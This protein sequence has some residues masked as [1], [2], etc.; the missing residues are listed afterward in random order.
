MTV[1]VDPEFNELYKKYTEQHPTSSLD[2]SDP[3]AMRYEGIMSTIDIYSK[4]KRKTDVR[5]SAKMLLRAYD[6]I[7]KVGLAKYLNKEI[8]I[9][10]S[11]NNR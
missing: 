9:S 7:E 2:F 4:A 5:T 1:R 11:N 10:D 6:D 3:E 8:L